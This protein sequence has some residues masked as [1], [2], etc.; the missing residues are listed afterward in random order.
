M[1]RS[2]VSLGMFTA[3]ALS[4]AA[5]K[6]GL[7]AM[8]PPPRRA[9][10]VSSL[11]T[12]VQTFDFLE[13]EA[14]FLCFIFDHRLCPDMPISYHNPPPPETFLHRSVEPRRPSFKVDPSRGSGPTA[15]GSRRRSDR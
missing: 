12:L 6:R 7:P 9:D 2:M 4:A 11:M 13:S 15:C 3:R 8:S 1:A 10:S 14:S 5:R